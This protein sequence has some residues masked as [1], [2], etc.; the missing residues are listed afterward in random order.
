MYGSFEKGRRLLKKNWIESA[1][2][3]WSAD[4]G[5]VRRRETGQRGGAVF[6]D[7]PDICVPKSGYI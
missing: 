5:R 6:P 3:F 1:A 4:T 2:K 7:E